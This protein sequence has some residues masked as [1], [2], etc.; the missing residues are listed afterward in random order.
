MQSKKTDKCLSLEQLIMLKKSRAKKVLQNKNP[1]LRGI[2]TI[3][4]PISLLNILLKICY[5]KIILRTF[6]FFSFP[7]ETAIGAE[8]DASTDLR[9]LHGRETE[10][11][12]SFHVPKL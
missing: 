1:F 11:G 12:Q 7:L 4:F 3:L 10:H 6:F 2:F 9:S 8:I 5:R